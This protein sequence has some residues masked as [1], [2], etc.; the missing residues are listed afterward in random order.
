M[1]SLLGVV[2]VGIIAATLFSNP[3]N[4]RPKCVWEGHAWQCWN[5][6]NHHQAWRER[7]YRHH[8]RAELR[9]DRRRVEHLSNR[10]DRDLHSGS[11]AETR[12]GRHGLRGAERELRMDR[13]DRS[14]E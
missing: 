11:S 14:G 9:H 4:A 2:G 6:A 1:K 5:S 10:L 12:Y 8:E 7:D 13:R 3:A